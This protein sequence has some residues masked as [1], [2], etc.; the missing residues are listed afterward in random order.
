VNVCVFIA[1]RFFLADGMRSSGKHGSPPITTIEFDRE[2]VLRIRNG[3]YSDGLTGANLWKASRILARY[4]FEHPDQIRGR[5]VVELGCGLALPSLLA[6][7]L[8]AAAVA[9]TDMNAKLTADQLEENAALCGCVGRV[10][11]MA[12]DFSL[13]ADVLRARPGTWDVVLFAD[14]VYSGV[15]GAALPHA[16]F[17][18]MTAHDH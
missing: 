11:G 6:A 10:Q 14:C 4:L 16:W 15:M 8:G 18:R 7:R 17:P 1:S 13:Q 12:I 3:M 5:R 2:L 9:A